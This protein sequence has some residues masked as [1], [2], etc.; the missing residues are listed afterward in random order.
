MLNTPSMSNPSSVAAAVAA[1]NDATKATKERLEMWRDRL[2]ENE[3]Q[4][5]NKHCTDIGI[6]LITETNSWLDGFTEESVQE[7][8][9]FSVSDMV[10]LTRCSSICRMRGRTSRVEQPATRV[11][12]AVM[13]LVI[14]SC[15]HSHPV[16]EP[17]TTSQAI[18]LE[19]RVASLLVHRMQR[20]CESIV[21]E[22]DKQQV[23]ES[24]QAQFDH[25]HNVERQ[26][27][28]GDKDLPE[29]EIGPLFDVGKL[30][31]KLVVLA[32]RFFACYHN[33]HRLLNEYQISTTWVPRFSERERRN[34]QEWLVDRCKYEPSDV[35]QRRIKEMYFEMQLPVGARLMQYRREKTKY[36]KQ[37]AYQ[38]L[39]AELGTELAAVVPPRMSSA[40]FN[41]ATICADSAHEYYD[42]LL[43]CMFE[44]MLK[45]TVKF[46]FSA[47][48][49]LEG[50]L[51]LPS[52][53]EILRRLKTGFR[54]RLP[55]LAQFSGARWMIHNTRKWIP[56]KD[57]TEAM[58]MWINLVDDEFGGKLADGSTSLPDWCT[59]MLESPASKRRT[60][61]VS[62]EYTPTAVLLKAWR[63]EDEERMEDE[64]ADAFHAAQSLDDTCYGDY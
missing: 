15:R 23:D 63:A 22:E 32:S 21:S 12:Q 25:L 39:G 62:G 47:Y 60:N 64:G 41:M 36:E 29:P 49:L 59:E 56:L 58:L 54:P 55:V 5:R 48:L 18:A 44:Y 28:E 9:G 51:L 11:L 37:S 57:V 38:V 19:D 27:V 20:G 8:D 43:L 24:T 10:F 35:L 50:V 61:E 2:R 45:Q 6:D 33:E 4:L 34:V 7:T 26:P 42:L 30:G 16:P 13:E 46:D 52:S 53:G 40:N 17:L 14:Q 1:R 3:I 31:Y